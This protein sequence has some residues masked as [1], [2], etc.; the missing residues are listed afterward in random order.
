MAAKYSKLIT[1]MVSKKLTKSLKIDKVR[2]CWK[3]Y[4]TCLQG[5]LALNICAEMLMKFLMLNRTDLK[6]VCLILSK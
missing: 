2:W 1:E 4:L 5:K 6:K 3:L